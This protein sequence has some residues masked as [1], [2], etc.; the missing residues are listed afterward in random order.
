MIPPH[1]GDVGKPVN[2]LLNKDYPIGS[3]KLEVNTTTPNGI[4]FTV[5]GTK[6][7]KSGHIHSELKTKYTDKARGLTVTEHWNA[8]NVLGA[9]IEL[10]D[11]IT[12]GLKLDLLASILP[13]TGKK[14]AK[15]GL[16]FKQAN[17]FTRGSVD[18]FAKDGPTV[19]SDVV[20]GNDGFLVGGDI[21]YNVNEA[22]ISRY[23]VA[24]GYI[25]PD[26]SVGVHATQK[27][28]VFSASYFHKVNREVEAG[29]KATWNKAAS[30][31]VAIEVG[32]KYN[33]DSSA[34][35]KAKIDNAG[36]LGLGYTQVLRPGVKL[37]L[38]G[39]FDTARLNEN[40]H[41]VGLSLTFDS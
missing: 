1:F 18:L 4:K 41:R 14:H 27:F 40:V 39:S 16:E 26:Y 34:F 28:S 9:Q 19:H 3:A 24:A 29:A 35:V 8:T 17:V 13:A 31:A 22:T 10:Q 11:T 15:A 7:N 33:I 37:A 6:D 38:G 20:V 21:A 36:R 32:T 5:S 2:D 12:K 25:A 23:N 30:D